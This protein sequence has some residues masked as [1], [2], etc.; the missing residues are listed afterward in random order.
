MD[1]ELHE[2]GKINLKELLGRIRTGWTDYWDR[3]EEE[4]RKWKEEDPDSYYAYM[5]RYS[6]NPPYL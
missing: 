4:M 5:N 3:Y 6:G 1:R 2:K